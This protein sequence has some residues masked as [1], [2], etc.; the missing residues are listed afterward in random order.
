MCGFAGVIAWEDKYRTSREVLARMS[1]AV[2]HRG[3]DG[4]GSWFNHEGEVTAERPQAALAFRRLAII[5]LDP[6]ANQPMTDGE[7]RWIVFNGEIYNYRELRRELSTLDPHY[8]WKTEGDT[9]VLLR[10]YAQW[11]EK[12][13]EHLNG[14]FAFAVWDEGKKELYLA[15]DRM[16]QKPLYFGYIGADGVH[17]FPLTR[18]NTSKCSGTIEGLAPPRAIVF[19]SELRAAVAA[20]LCDTELDESAL[21]GYMH[22]GYVALDETIYRG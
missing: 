16:G 7:G 20:G 3:P 19:A 2:A 9:E 5:D 8:A 1:A 21:T 22:F 13:V 12:S 4:E 15:R 17:P 18:W 6:R 11:G 14:M 10:S